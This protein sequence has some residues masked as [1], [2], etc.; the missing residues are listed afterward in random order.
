M[1]LNLSVTYHYEPYHPATI[2]VRH[3]R[4]PR[5]ISETRPPGP[6]SPKCFTLGTRSLA[7]NGRMDFRISGHVVR[8]RCSRDA[9]GWKDKSLSLYL[10]PPGLSFLVLLQIFQLDGGRIDWFFNARILR[11]EC[12]ILFQRLIASARSPFLYSASARWERC[13]RQF[14]KRARR[15]PGRRIPSGW[16]SDSANSSS[17]THN[18]PALMRQNPLCRKPHRRLPDILDG[19]AVVREQPLVLRIVRQAAADK[20]GLFY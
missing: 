3:A 6:D 9:G 5:Y 13:E 15:N 18:M 17:I 1:S 14:F 10:F 2:L 19:F 16:A 8:G 20:S 7:G 12:E 4:R 11:I